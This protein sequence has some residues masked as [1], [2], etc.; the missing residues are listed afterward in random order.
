MARYEPPPYTVGIEEEYLLVDPA[1][2]ELV[3]EQ[4]LQ[5]AIIEEV[6]ATVSEEDV[7]MVTPEFLKAQVEVGTAICHSIQSARDRLRILRTAVAEAAGKRGVAPIASS[8]HPTARWSH[9]QHT[10]KERYA[11][12]ANDLQEVARR[13]V[14]SGMHVHV[15]VADNEHRIDLLGQIAYFLPHLLVLT[16]SSP[17]WQGR[18]TGLKCYRLA[19]FDELPRTGLPEHFDSWSHYEKHVKSLVAAGAIEDGSK[20]WWDIRPHFK[21]PTLEMRIADICTRLDDGIAVAATYSCLIS[22]LQRL[23]RKNQ[24]WRNYSNMLIQENRWRAQRYGADKGLIDFGVTQTVPYPDL[25]DEILDLIAEDADRLNCTEEVAH[26]RMILQRGTSA[27]NQLRVFNAAKAAGKSDSETFKEVVD[28]L[29]TA[30][31][32]DL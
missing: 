11:M 9:L 18:N 26:T 2:G 8:T 19:V 4:E 21:F 29:I 23:R 5:E 28:W 16:T 7:G 22:M 27:D 1:T 15:G 6:K 12:L 20:L 31:V 3:S 10:D 24:R 30:T 25:L 13:L 14:I 32:A 17:F